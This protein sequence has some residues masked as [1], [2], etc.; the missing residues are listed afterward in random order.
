M[1]QSIKEKGIDKFIESVGEHR[2]DD[3]LKLVVADMMGKPDNTGN[4]EVVNKLRELI[5][6][7]KQNRR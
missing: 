2:I 4:M 7:H 1:I 6:Q 5:E 3:M